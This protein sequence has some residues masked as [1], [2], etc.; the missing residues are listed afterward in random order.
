LVSFVFPIF[1][2]CSVSP[3][4]FPSMF[5]LLYCCYL[6]ASIMAWDSPIASGLGFG[7]LYPG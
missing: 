4:F 7:T 2:V 6:L 3:L 1:F 5:L